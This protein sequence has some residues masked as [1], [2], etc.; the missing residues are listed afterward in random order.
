MLSLFRIIWKNLKL[1]FRSKTSALIV[2]F[3]PLLIVF[4]VGV[5]FDNSSSYR[6][7]IAVYSEG[8]NELSDSVVSRLES[9]FR[10]ERSKT[11]Q[12][13][14]N[15]IEQG[16]SHACM[17][18]S[19][20]FKI[21]ESMNNEI[22]FYVDYSKVNLVYMILDS[23]SEEVNARASEISMNIT[24]DIL[25]RVED[26][27]NAISSKKPL[28]MD[29]TTENTIVGKEADS[30]KSGLQVLDL[31]FD[32][33]GFKTDEL[34]SRTDSI[35]A[36]INATKMEVMAVMNETNESIW[37][38][39][40]D[41]NSLNSS[42]SNKGEM[43]T[44][45]RGLW[46]QFE[47]ISE[48]ITKEESLSAQDFARISELLNEVDA[49]LDK[50]K[51][52]LDA[53]TSSRD[54]TLAKIDTIKKKLSDSLNHIADLQNTLNRIDSNLGSIQVTNAA[55]IVRPIETTIRPVTTE[56]TNLNYTFPTLIVLVIMFVS[57]LLSSTLVIMEKTSKAYLRNF[58]TPTRDITFVLGTFFTSFLLIFLQICIIVGVS[59]IFFRSQ[60]SNS[61]LYSS[62]VLLLISTFFILLGMLIG[63]VFN[64]EETSSLAAISVGS[65]CLFL[66]NV[67]L[68][69]E[70]M[71]EYVVK[72][73]NY[74]P[75]V[76]SEFML[77]RV[78]IFGAELYSIRVEL[79]LMASSCLLLFGMILI[80]QKAMKKHYLSRY[81]RKIDPV[82]RFTRNK[83]KKEEE[84][85]VNDAKVLEDKDNGVVTEEKKVAKPKAK[86]SPKKKA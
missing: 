48:A 31:S 9:S 65:V 11:E 27:R 69:L 60:I 64:S 14:I 56:S 66:S 62:A 59:A 15:S 29:L 6:V 67:I 10:A 26:T 58:T 54:N 36:R 63:Y 84:K 42:V 13:C 19:K 34:I 74:N 45:V 46:D 5:A 71:P 25:T 20:D 24:G 79:G 85:K 82:G 68:P 39:L 83:E 80:I 18:F 8:Y 32:S 61:L 21:G 81:A 38:V 86:K 55:D 78:I 4:L 76:I 40:G 33:S 44:A 41:I 22:I 30:I 43:D 77:R 51:S 3:G 35:E 72:F 70:S 2:I 23:V 7:N 1:L 53:A 73:A 16:S 37:G 47:K 50:T 12:D 52:K 17:V 28:L 49:N 75:F 57:L